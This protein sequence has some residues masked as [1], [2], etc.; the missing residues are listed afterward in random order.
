MHNWGL[1]THREYHAEFLQLLH[2]LVAGFQ[3]VELIQF[4]GGDA[5]QLSLQQVGVLQE[6]CQLISVHVPTKFQGSHVCGGIGRARIWRGLANELL[7]NPSCA[8]RL[9]SVVRKM[10]R[11]K[12]S[13]RLS[14]QDMLGLVLCVSGISTVPNGI[15]LSR[16]AHAPVA[17]I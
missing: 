1:G 14:L 16:L 12:S 3:C 15:S 11:E 4:R 5:K 13:N 17:A 9:Q 7:H 6:E 10:E 8:L 2:L